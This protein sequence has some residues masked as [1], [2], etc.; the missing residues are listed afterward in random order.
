VATAQLVL[1][2]V[3]REL[4]GSTSV[5]T[6]LQHLGQQVCVNLSKSAGDAD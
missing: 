2:G 6:S 5:I 3:G 1:G 4:S